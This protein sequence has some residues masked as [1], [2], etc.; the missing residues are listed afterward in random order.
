MCQESNDLADALSRNN[1]HITSSLTTTRPTRATPLCLPVSILNT[2]PTMSGLDL[3]SLGESVCQYYLQG[4]APSTNRSYTRQL[5][6]DLSVFVLQLTLQS[7]YTLLVAI[8]V[9]KQTV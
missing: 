3:L 5:S 1:H 8:E 9:T 4:L 7:I 2:H 6:V